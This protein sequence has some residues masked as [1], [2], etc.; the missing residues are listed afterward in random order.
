MHLILDSIY[1]FLQ[2]TQKITH[3]SKNI[4][5]VTWMQKILI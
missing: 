4:S 5:F 2:L 3:S 1:T